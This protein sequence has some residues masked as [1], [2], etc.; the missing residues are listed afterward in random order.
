VTTM[1]PSKREVQYI[2]QDGDGYIFMDTENDEQ[3]TLPEDKVGHRGRYLKEGLRLAIVLED[4]QPI[5]LELPALVELLIT[6]TQEDEFE[7]PTQPYKT[8]L[9][10]TG[11]KVCV[12]SH[13]T[14]G[15][16]ILVDTRTGQCIVRRSLA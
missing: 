12:P 2:Y 13:I 4:S 6:D 14:V 3:M 5:G 15:E 7:E 10:E 9:T 8:A 11:L 16:S 1:L